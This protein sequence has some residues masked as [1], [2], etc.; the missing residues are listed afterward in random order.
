MKNQIPFVYLR[1]YLEDVK[2]AEKSRIKEL[3]LASFFSPPVNNT[4]PLVIL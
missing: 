3:L 1:S 2:N 4:K